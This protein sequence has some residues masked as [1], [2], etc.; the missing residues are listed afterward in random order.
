[1]PYT[2]IAMATSDLLSS[3]YFFILY[4]VTVYSGLFL[5][6]GTG[7]SNHEYSADLLPI[8]LISHYGMHPFYL[9]PL[10]ERTLVP[11]L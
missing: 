6:F 5:N 4:V 1:M 7:H 3:P 8:P 2:G 11:S 10:A 9:L